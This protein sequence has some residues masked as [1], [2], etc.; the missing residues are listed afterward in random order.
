MMAA[1]PATRREAAFSAAR[2]QTKK[3]MKPREAIKM[4]IYMTKR[5]MPAA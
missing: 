4:E 1:S 2:Y 5:V 3:A